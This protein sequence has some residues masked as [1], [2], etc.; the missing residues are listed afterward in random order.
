MDDALIDE[1]GKRLGAS[2]LVFAPHQDDETLACG[3][4]V[5]RKRR[6]GA[7]VALVFMTDG[8]TSHRRFMDEAALRSLRQAEALEAANVLGLSVDDVHF[9]GFPDGELKRSREAAV[10]KVRD[11]LS[12]YLPDEVYVP[13]GRDG[14]ADHESTH[15]AVLEALANANC[16]PEILEYPVWFWNRW[17]WVSQEITLD[18][19]GFHRLFR[20]LWRCFGRREFA[21]FGSK[22]FVRDVLEQKMDALS[23][24]RSQMTVLMPGSGWPTLGEVSGGEFLRCFFQEYE[25]FRCSYP[26]GSTGPSGR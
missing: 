20:S 22:V 6:A 17:P 15:Q 24:H 18:R 7:P 3:G 10:G 1:T 16:E 19:S 9:L 12:R 23:R 25:V 13:Y 21:D 14:L 11:L 4:T 2:A 8:S 26:M 5:I